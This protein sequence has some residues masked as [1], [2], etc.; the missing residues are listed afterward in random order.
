VLP[1][2]QL[3]WGFPVRTAPR[4]DRFASTPAAQVT[5]ASDTDPAND[6]QLNIVTRRGAVDSVV[7]LAAPTAPFLVGAPGVF[8]ATV[9][10]LGIAA[11]IGTTTVELVAL[12][13]PRPDRGTCAAPGGGALGRG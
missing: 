10:N 9:R 1:R 5:N 3:G 11:T 8:K 7:T 6:S 12:S 4:D 13:A 2:A